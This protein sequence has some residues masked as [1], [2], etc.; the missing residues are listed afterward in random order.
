MPGMRIPSRWVNLGV[1]A[2]IA[3]AL[4]AAMFL[5]FRTI[6]VERAERAQVRKTTEVLV[7]L[8]N[9]SGATL[10]AETAQ[11]GYLITLDPRYLEPYEAGRLQYRPAI[12]HLRQLLNHG[13]TE[14]QRDLLDEIQTLA[15]AKFAEIGETVAMLQRGDLLDARRQVLTD[16]GQEL[17]VRLRRAV[18]EM[19]Q[20]EGGLLVDAASDSAQAEG[21]V[22]PLLSMVAGL[23]IVALLFGYRLVGRAAQAEAEAAQASALAEARDRADLLARELNHRVK[24]MF[25]VILAIVRMSARDAPEAK[26]VVERIAERIHALLIAHDVTQGTADSSAGSLQA[27]VETTLAPYRSERMRA[28][29][30]GPDIA[31]PAKQIT[32]LGLVLH[33]L[34]TNAVKYGAWASDGLLTVEWGINGPALELRWGEECPMAGGEPETKGFGSM[35]M[36]S[37]ARQLGGTIERNF[38]SGGLQVQIHFPINS[39]TP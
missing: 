2:V 1:L 9:L 18:R 11:R 14:R 22:L 15:D 28:L 30:S 37:A 3:F 17:M 39:N 27:L 10:N 21:Q 19:E 12:G 24:N 26:P 38:T 23:L 6:E 35:L 25:A 13:E 32:P 16:E 7:E 31:L 8:R 5:V 29:I 20:I 4:L 34:T 33:E 36:Q